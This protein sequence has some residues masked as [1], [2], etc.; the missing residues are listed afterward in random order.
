VLNTP[1]KYGI[2][3]AFFSRPFPSSQPEANRL[4]GSP[5]LFPHLNECRSWEKIVM[6]VGITGAN[7]FL[8]NHFVRYVAS[9][10]HHIVAF[11][12]EN[13]SDS[14]ISHYVHQ[15][16]RGDVTDPAGLEPFLRNCDVVFHLAGINR[17]WL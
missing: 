6:R 17:Y 5:L 4:D 14:L 1:R 13:T 7:G 16:F 8:G 9:L 11:I 2:D 15:V 10:G 3:H 12:E